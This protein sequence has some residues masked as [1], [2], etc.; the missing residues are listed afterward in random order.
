MP[1]SNAWETAT[2][3]EDIHATSAVSDAEWSTTNW[4][5]TTSSRPGGRPQGS[6]SAPANAAPAASGSG[7]VQLAEAPG[8][9]PDRARPAQNSP[10]QAT[11]RQSSPAQSG[12]AQQAPG[13]DGRPL[14]RYQKLL[15]EAAARNGSAPSSAA[16]GKVDLVE[17]VPSADDVTLEDSGLVGRKA[18]ERIL[19]GRL[20]EERGLDGHDIRR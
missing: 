18:I 12:P 10:A 5:G 7:N 13:N 16:R 1:E 11:P 19:G 9:R 20:I 6:G 3:P 15:N 4:A 8:A 2:V 17:D 14:R